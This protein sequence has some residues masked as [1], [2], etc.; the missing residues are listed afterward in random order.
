[1]S[2]SSETAP[3]RWQPVTR[4]YSR[5]ATGRIIGRIVAFR[6]GSARAMQALEVRPF[7][8]KMKREN[9]C[10]EEAGGNEP[11]E[12]AKNQRQP[13]RLQ[14]TNGEIGRASCRERV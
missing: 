10:L 13:V 14:V 2:W 5:R 6:A 1:M 3:P 8:Q 11:R 12:R 9:R 4:T 7:N